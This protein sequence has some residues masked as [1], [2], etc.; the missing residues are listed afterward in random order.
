MFLI[1][2]IKGLDLPKGNMERSENQLEAAKREVKEETGI[3]DLSIYPE[4]K[5]EIQYVY[6]KDDGPDNFQ[7]SC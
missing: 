4:F 6:V 7:K 2:R 5:K 1:T 3:T